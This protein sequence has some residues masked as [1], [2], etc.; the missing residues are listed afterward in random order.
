M[1]VIIV[2]PQSLSYGD[3]L[4]GVEVLGSVVSP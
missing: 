2:D 4:S 1:H 3:V